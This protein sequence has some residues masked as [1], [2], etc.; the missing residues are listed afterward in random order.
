MTA[1]KANPGGPRPERSRAPEAVE[2]RALG[3]ASEWK[4]RGDCYGDND[5]SMF[6]EKERAQKIVAQ[7]CLLLCP[8]QEECLA[9]AF[10]AD[11]RYG[12]WG[13]LTEKQR[14]KLRKA[15]RKK[16]QE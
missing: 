11:E 13:G 16:A 15:E 1:P 12:V 7:R 10:D 8:V 2:V 5:D 6:P 4:E 3:K 9:Y 14:E